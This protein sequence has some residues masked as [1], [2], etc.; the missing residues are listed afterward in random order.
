MDP[1]TAQTMIKLAEHYEQL[2]AE[3]TKELDEEKKTSHMFMM[4]GL[5]YGDIH[6]YS[7]DGVCAECN[8]LC[9]AVTPMPAIDY[10]TG[11]EID[12]E[13]RY[14]YKTCQKCKELTCTVCCDEIAWGIDYSTDDYDCGKCVKCIVLDGGSTVV[15]D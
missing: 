8:Q 2:L 11:D 13:N 1:I 5:C 9:F 4:M 3:K 15:R 12:V 10:E 14:S 7:Q 6:Y